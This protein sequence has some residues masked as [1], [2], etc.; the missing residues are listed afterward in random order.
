M[1][2]CGE[3][4]LYFISVLTLQKL[5]SI[6]LAACVLAIEAKFN[7]PMRAASSNP[8][9]PPV[10]KAMPES[11]SAKVMRLLQEFAR[12]EAKL[13]EWAE[14]CAI[15]AIWYLSDPFGAMRSANVGI[16]EELICELEALHEE[17]NRQRNAPQIRRTA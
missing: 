14:R 10:L 4:G 17:H 15:N 16:D 9:L 13:K 7:L 3:E 6:W 11:A 12:H 5:C 2:L 1:Y 8:I